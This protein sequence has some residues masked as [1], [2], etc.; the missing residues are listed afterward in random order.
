MYT[1]RPILNNGTSLSQLHPTKGASI[2]NS[3]SNSSLSM[4]LSSVIGD[5]RVFCQNPLLKLLDNIGSYTIANFTPF[6]YSMRCSWLLWHSPLLSS[7]NSN[8]HKFMKPPMSFTILEWFCI[9]YNA[10]AFSSLVDRIGFPSLSSFQ[11]QIP[12]PFLNN[13]QSNLILIL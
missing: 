8:S 2:P 10:K 3:S 1:S 12:P 6:L 5:M 4:N 9:C 13:F 11:S 7:A